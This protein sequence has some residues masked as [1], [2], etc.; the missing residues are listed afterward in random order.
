MNEAPDSEVYDHAVP[1]SK[2]AGVALLASV[3]FVGGGQLVKGHYWRFLAIWGTLIG[4]LVAIL[5]GGALLFPQGSALH[6]YVPK[7]AGIGYGLVWA[8]QLWDAVTRV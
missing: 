3:L 4:L 1:K 6:D 8:Y 5:G 7:A 2:K